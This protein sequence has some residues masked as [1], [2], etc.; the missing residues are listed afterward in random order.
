VLGLAR[1]VGS[2]AL[3]LARFVFEVALILNRL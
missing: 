3:I 2:G 1:V